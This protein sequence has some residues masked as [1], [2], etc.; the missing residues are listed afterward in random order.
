M[1]A[2]VGRH[3]ALHVLPDLERFEAELKIVRNC[4][5]KYE[6]LKCASS[7]ALVC[8]VCPGFSYTRADIKEYLPQHSHS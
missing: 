4:F 6:A 7:S 3:Y 1:M 8:V 2:F 5:G